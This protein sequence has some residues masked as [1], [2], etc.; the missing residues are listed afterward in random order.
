[1]AVV[2]ATIGVNARASPGGEG[3]PCI[4][5]VPKQNPPLQ[6]IAMTTPRKHFTETERMM[7]ETC[8]NERMGIEEISR[9]L[10]KHRS[11]VC[12]ELKRNRTTVGTGLDET[13]CPRLSQP[14]YV[15]NACGEYGHCVK[16]RML[17]TARIADEHARDV[18][19]SSR[20][21]FNLTTDELKTI[22]DITAKGNENGLSMHHILQ[23]HKDEIHVSEKTLY[24]LV[25]AGMISVKRHHLPM[26]PYRKA[27]AAKLKKR[28]DRLD[29]KYLDG[30]RPDDY[31]IYRDSHRGSDVV[32][33]DSVVGPRGSS[34]VLLTMNFNCCGLMLAFIRDANTAQ[35]VVDIFNR[36]EDRLGLACFR[37]LFPVILTD[38]GSEFSWPDRI[39]RNELGQERTRVFYCHPYAASEKPHVEN[40]HENLRKI[41]EKH[42]PFDTLAQKDVDLAVCHVNSMVRKAYGNRTAI[43]RFIELFGENTAKRLNLKKIPA[44]DVCL[45]PELVGLGKKKG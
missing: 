22:S 37:R 26:A 34:K 41:L 44:D 18:L 42:L 8:I 15:C 28:K 40:N 1:M 35:S 24:R 32:E 6:E 36:L 45:K 3:G 7:L 10:V 19:V 27:R 12:R 13:P 21:G 43:D 2:L 14:P 9:R 33:I 29:R 30:R 25:N 20:D 23:T 4:Y 17:Y 38:N 5:L 39:E 16:Q 31:R 11:S